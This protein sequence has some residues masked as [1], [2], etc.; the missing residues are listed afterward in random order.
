MAPKYPHYKVWL[1]GEVVEPERANVSVFTS[2]AM[3]GA[4]VYEGIRLYWSESARNLF[5]WKLDLHLRRHFKNMRIMRMM[6]PYTLE[7]YGRS[8]I[9]WARSNAFREDVH[10][11]LVTYFGDG[12]P[13]DVK[14]YKPEDIEIGVWV[15]GGQRLHGGPGSRSHA[16]AMERGIDV[17]VSSWRRINDDSMPARVKSGSNYQNSRLA[18]VE[19]R[20]NHYDDALLLTRDGKLAEAPSANVM[21]VRDGELLSPPVTAGILEGITRG[22]MMELYAKQHNRKTVERDIDRSELYFADEIFICGS[23]EEVT[24]VISVD[25][26]PIGDG[27]PGPITRQLQSAYFHAVRGQ[28]PAYA[29][30]LTPVY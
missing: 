22:T 20:V 13:G 19:A 27:R 25:R 18:G 8:V 2:T 14:Q 3:R 17:C 6:P 11:R 30:M 10:C 5:V 24:P 29:T 4:N 16:E 23:A 26:I 21:V 15:A 7:E 12:G 1:N 28:D 9:E